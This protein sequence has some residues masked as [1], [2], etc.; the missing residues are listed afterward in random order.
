MTTA[1]S[2]STPAA[3]ERLTWLFTAL[4]E[5]DRRTLLAF[6]EFLAA[7]RPPQVPLSNLDPP[8]DPAT[9]QPPEPTPLPRPEQ[10][11]VIAAIRRLTLTYPMLDHGPMLHETSAL[12]TAHVL[13]GRP[14]TQ[15]ID[16]LE[17]LFRRKYQD[18][19]ATFSGRIGFDGSST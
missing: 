19:C 14:A 7:G 10:E 3:T 9:E 1:T 8:P 2:A 13:H 5:A 11:K 6:A 12:M 17:A 4:D 16:D 18:Y 15:V